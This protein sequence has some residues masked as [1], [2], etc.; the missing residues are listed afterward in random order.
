MTT[1]AKTELLLLLLLQTDAVVS[2]FVLCAPV[3]IPQFETTL[4]Q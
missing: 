1:N 3:L 4:Q 2:L